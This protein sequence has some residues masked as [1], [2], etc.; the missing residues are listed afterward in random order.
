MKN[1]F[2]TIELLVQVSHFSLV[3]GSRLF[4]L[5]GG[6]GGIFWRF[7]FFCWRTWICCRNSC[8]FVTRA[9]DLTNRCKRE[10]NP[11]GR[12]ESIVCISY[13]QDFRLSHI[14]IRE[15]FRVYMS[16]LTIIFKIAS[17]LSCVLNLWCKV[18][19]FSFFCFSS[20]VRN[21]NC[22]LSKKKIFLSWLR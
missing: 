15:E 14:N 18:F 20:P 12:L 19:W 9:L 7:F 13:T 10:K 4:C 22:Y 21:D 8:R 1:L 6:F 5:S 2:A 3:L 17:K 11:C 16:I